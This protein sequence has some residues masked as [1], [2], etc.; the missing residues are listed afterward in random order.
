GIDVWDCVTTFLNGITNS[1]LITAA[2]SGI[3]VGAVSTFAGGISNSGTLAAQSGNGVAVVGATTFS[4]GISNG[5]IITAQGVP[6]LGF[7]RGDGIPGSAA[8][9]VGSGRARGST[10]TPGSASRASA[11]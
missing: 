8:A 7:V 9:V 4:G 6:A 5:G 11:G 1:G 10:A 3:F 2:G